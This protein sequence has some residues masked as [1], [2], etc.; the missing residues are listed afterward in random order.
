MLSYRFIPYDVNFRNRKYKTD[1]K[2][3]ISLSLQVKGPFGWDDGKVE[4]QKMKRG[5]KSGRIEKILVSL[6]YVWLEGW[7][8]GGI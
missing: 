8:S 7:K 2:K 5:W 1:Q 4:G 6:I 3:I